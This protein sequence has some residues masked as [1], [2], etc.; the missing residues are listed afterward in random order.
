MATALVLGFGPFPGAPDNPSAEL[1]RAV[2]R[3]RR[4]ALGGIRLISAVI[5]TTYAAVAD[6]LPALVR[7]HDP[8][9]VLLFGLAMRAEYV[10][11]E[12][13]AVNAAST[14][15]PDAARSNL[16]R[17][18]LMRGGLAELRV[19]ARPRDLLAAIRPMVAARPSRD[20]GRYICNAALYSSLEAA[21]RTGR[22]KKIA[23]VHI[24]HPRVR[25][26]AGY[27]GARKRPPMATLVR[28]GEAALVALLADV[29]RG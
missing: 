28:A 26:R 18:E 10:R 19:R 3:R 11:I 27:P 2:A 15:H 22:P 23:F 1:A 8:D 16:T 14:V 5:P 17:R 24:P 6:D 13:R 12:S 21:R 9:V 29:R 7:R 20:A 4:P 25:R